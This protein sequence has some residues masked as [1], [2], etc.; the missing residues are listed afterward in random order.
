MRFFV[1]SLCKRVGFFGKLLFGVLFFPHTF[2]LSPR[3]QCRYFFF[4]SAH[5]KR[6]RY[7]PRLISSTHLKLKKVSLSAAYLL[8]TLV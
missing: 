2:L 7:T 8:S 6:E 4:M 1:R 5:V 3:S